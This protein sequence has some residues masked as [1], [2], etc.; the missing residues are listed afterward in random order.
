MSPTLSVVSSPNEADTI[1]RIARYVDS[2]PENSRIFTITP[3][4][5]EHVLKTYNTGNRPK[6]PANIAKY[7][8]HMAAASWALA[9]DTIKFSDA[10]ILRDGQ[11]R[12]MACVRSGTPFVTHV[13]FGIADDAFS[14]MDQ[15]KNRDGSDLL[16]IAGYSNTTSLAAAVRWAY[17]IDEGRVKSRDTLPP[18]K[19]LELVTERYQTLPNLIP[20]ASAVY[21]LTGQPIGMVAALLHVF[22]RKNI[23]KA[24]QFSSAWANGEHGGQY[25]SLGKLQKEIARLASS[26]S[27]RVHDVVRAAL[28]VRA[29]NAFVEGRKGNLSDFTWKPSDVFPEIGG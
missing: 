22:G 1:A 11:N 19:T 24:S 18:N 10:K 27:G 8:S 9:G 20:I 29:W 25:A 5:A 3:G 2:P 6:K 21:R 28:V 14:L 23:S 12:L 13:V 16:S 17:L 26:S 15:G 4:V 7:A